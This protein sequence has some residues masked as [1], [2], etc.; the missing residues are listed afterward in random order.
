[1][2]SELRLK[3]VESFLQKEISRMIISGTI[4]DPRVDPMVYISRIEVS[5]DLAYGKVY[6]SGY[7]E[8]SKL[9]LSAKALNHA[10]GFI[11][12]Q[13]AKKLRMRHTPKLTFYSDTSI[14]EGFAVNQLI[15]DNLPE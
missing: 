15:R 7:P 6:V 8:K 13:L 3:R 1:M 4:H 2:P 5:K 12:A 11:Q 14:Q 9:Q 10:A